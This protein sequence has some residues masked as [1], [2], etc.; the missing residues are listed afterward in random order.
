MW[1]VFL[2]SLR[3]CRPMLLDSHEPISEEC[4]RTVEPAVAALLRLGIT[5]QEF[6]EDV[7]R[8]LGMVRC[9]LDYRQPIA[10]QQLAAL[11]RTFWAR[12][13]QIPN[14]PAETVQQIRSIIKSCVAELRLLP[15][16]I[17]S[18]GEMA[19]PTGSET[20]HS[21]SNAAPVQPT[22]PEHN[23]FRGGGNGAYPPS[24]RSR[25]KALEKQPTLFDFPVTN[26]VPDEAPHPAPACSP[27]IAPTPT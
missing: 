26:P 1:P 2:G 12:L 9:V 16:P 6:I 10:R 19:P 7:S 25:P 14:L 8:A 27:A 23:G 13:P 4:A 18:N 21:P 20:Q 15:E 3:S 17:A 5:Q 24:H 22:L 11:G